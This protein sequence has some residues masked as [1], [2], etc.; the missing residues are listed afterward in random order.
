MGATFSPPMQ[1]TQIIPEIAP[2]RRGRPGK[3]QSSA[4]S[5]AKPSPSPY[6]GGSKTLSH[7]PFAA[8]DGDAKKNG[9]ELS[10]RFPTLDQFDIL[11]EKGDK[12]DFEPTVKETKSEDEDLSQRL[13]NALA[14]DA[15][16]RRPSPERQVPPTDRRSQTS[17][18]R[19]Q[20][21]QEVSTR[22][23]APLY[24]PTPQRPAMISTGTMTSPSQ[25]PRLQEPKISSRP[26]YR[27]P[28]PEHERRPSSQPWTE[29]EQKVT[30]YKA[31][32]PPSANLRPEASP[33]LSS[34][35]LSNQSNSARP[36]ME[37]LRRPSGLEAADSVGRSKSAIA[38]ARPVS[39]QAS[40][41]YDLSRGSETSRSSLD[42]L[43]MQYEGGAPLRPVR[44][45]IDRDY[46][47]ANISS[48][49]DYLRA[50]EE[51]ESNRKREKRSSSGA[52]HAKRGSLSSLSL[53]GSKTLFAGRFGEAF[54]R[55]ESTNQDKPSTPTAEDYPQHN[56][57]LIKDSEALDSPPNE[58]LS[59]YE[60]DVLEDVDR[61]DISPEMRR[62]LERRRLSQEEKRVAKAAAE[63]RRR[64]AEGD[65]S[66]QHRSRAILNRVQNFIGES[67]KPQVAPKTATGYGKYTDANALQAKPSGGDSQLPSSAKSP[68]SRTPG[69][70]YGAREG[71][72]ALPDR[73]EGASAPAGLPHSATANSTGYPSVRPASRPTAPPKPK[74][75]RVGG[76]DSSRPSTSQDH[77]SSIHATP[78]SPAA[79]DWEANFSRRFPSLSGLE[80]ETEIEVP[81]Y[82]KL[83]TREV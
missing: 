44:T 37:S 67:N 82:P 28:P 61:D 71:T 4:H 68:I 46:E 79:E 55:F 13:T 54:R 33:R 26:I 51:E 27:F 58:G 42:L 29:D 47:R 38:K 74:N 76:Q 11:H 5:S 20:K 56:K 22:Q 43:H 48:D 45:E 53:S 66:G 32:S 2:M 39:V 23:Q 80:M 21:P 35:R 77:S 78:T 14:D 62:E 16:A 19:A 69:P 41:R 70:I 40:S 72:M 64:V 17:P 24:Q 34:D 30:G 12:F 3:P 63:Y 73:R 8:L 49:M 6:R 18:E 7:D 10:N 1:E 57:A 83:R 9:D 50:K 25:T 31:P 36:S 52:K 59:S 15:F 81:K 75:L 65:G 60:D